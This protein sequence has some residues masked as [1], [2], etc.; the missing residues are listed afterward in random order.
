MPRL[1]NEERLRAIGMLE[2]AMVQQQVACIMGC[3]RRAIRKLVQRYRETGTV[4][5]RPRSGRPKVTTGPLHPFKPSAGSISIK[6]GRSSEACVPDAENVW[7]SVG[8]TPTIDFFF[9]PFSFLTFFS[10]NSVGYALLEHVS[11]SGR[12]PLTR[13]LLLSVPLK[14]QVSKFI[15]IQQNKI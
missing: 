13:L 5:D 4:A 1:S 6:S 10:L 2:A 11:L 12:T 15:A 3:Q 7:S 9:V 14:F 8:G